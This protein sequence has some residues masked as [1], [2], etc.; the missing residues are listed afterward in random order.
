MTSNSDSESAWVC[1]TL[2]LVTF[3]C[4]PFQYILMCLSSLKISPWKGKCISSCEAP[5]CC[6]NREQTRGQGQIR[7][8]PKLFS[9]AG[10]VEFFI[11]QLTSCSGVATTQLLHIASFLNDLEHMLAQGRTEQVEGSPATS[12]GI[13]GQKPPPW[14]DPHSSLQSLLF[15]MAMGCFGLKVGCVGPWNADI[16]LALPRVVACVSGLYNDQAQTFMKPAIRLNNT[17]H[18]IKVFHPNSFN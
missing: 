15:S 8:G 17:S 2:K 16:S 4:A 9:R 10:Q 13:W 5:S 18:G 14:P 1:I 11:L 6:D 12:P 3:H 7:T